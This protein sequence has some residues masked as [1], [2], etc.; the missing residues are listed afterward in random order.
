MEGIHNYCQKKLRPKGNF[1]PGIEQKINF[2]NKSFK[3]V[4]TSGLVL[5]KHFS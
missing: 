4:W 5:Q 3:H 2:T 1:M